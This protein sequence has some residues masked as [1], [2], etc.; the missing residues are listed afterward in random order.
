M[1]HSNIYKW[2]GEEEKKKKNNNSLLNDT[3]SNEATDTENYNIREIQ[4]L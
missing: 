4:N 1:T 3:G 2:K